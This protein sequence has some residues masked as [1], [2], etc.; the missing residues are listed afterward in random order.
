MKLMTI[1]LACG[2]VTGVVAIVEGQHWVGVDR[3]VSGPRYEIIVTPTTAG[4]AVFLDKDSGDSW[5]LC[6]DPSKNQ[7]WCTLDRG[8]V[9]K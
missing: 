1:G 6:P 7:R 8:Q 4:G 5:F 2:L 9:T 3:H